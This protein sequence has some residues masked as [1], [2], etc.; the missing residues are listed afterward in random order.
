MNQ[1]Q[2]NDTKNRERGLAI[3]AAAAGN[4]IWGFSFLFT[5]V[6]MNYTTPDVLLSIRF[7][8]AV[9]IMTVLAATGKMPIRLKGKNLTFLTMFQI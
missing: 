1:T 2:L 3:L 9:A 7:I 5:K 8:I 6:A 4:T